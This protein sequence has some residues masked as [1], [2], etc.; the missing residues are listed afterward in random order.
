MSERRLELVDRTIAIAVIAWHILRW[1][2]IWKLSIVY[3]NWGFFIGEIIP[4]VFL[5]PIAL[6]LISNRFKIRLTSFLA[7]AILWGIRF[8]FSVY[9]DWKQIIGNKPAPM[10]KGQWIWLFGSALLATYAAWRFKRLRTNSNRLTF[11]VNS[12][13]QFGE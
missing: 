4:I 9:I 12:M 10:S 2:W 11:G 7:A 3:G 8:S 6:W 5:T 13:E 1:I